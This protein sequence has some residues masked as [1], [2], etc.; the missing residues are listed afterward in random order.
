VKWIVAAALLS[1][2]IIAEEPPKPPCNSQNVAKFWPDQA[3]SNPEARRRAAQSGELEIC[4]HGTWRYHWEPVTVN[5][6]QIRKDR[7]PSETETGQQV[8]HPDR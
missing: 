6:S 2:P 5:I 1:L 8:R 4:S 3:N 7:A